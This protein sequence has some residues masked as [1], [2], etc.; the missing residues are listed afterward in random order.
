MA[1]CTFPAGHVIQTVHS[2]N[3]YEKQ[4]SGTSETSHD[5]ASGVA[6]VPEITPT[7]T[8][9]H[10]LTFWNLSYK[11][12]R[13]DEKDGRGNIA[14]KYKIGDSGTEAYV[15][16]S[17][18]G[19]SWGDILGAYDYGADN[20]GIQLAGNYSFITKLSPSTTTKVVFLAYSSVGNAGAATVQNPG[21]AHSLILMMEIAG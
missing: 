8:S 20:A 2:V 11:T 9:S 18:G 13:S 4:H 1:N 15:P 10:I 6:W 7:A 12:W 17:A 5:S 19:G 3:T 14:L 16:S 21:A